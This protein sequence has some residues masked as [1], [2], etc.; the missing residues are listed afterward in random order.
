MSG[1][2]IPPLIAIYSREMISKTIG[3]SLDLRFS[4]VFNGSTLWPWIGS[5]FESLNVGL[6]VVHNVGACVYIYIYITYIYIYTPYVYIYNMYTY[7]YSS[8]LMLERVR[9]PLPFWTDF[10]IS[11]QFQAA[12]PHPVSQVR[13]TPNRWSAC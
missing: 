3:C 2:L 7:S 13:D 10:G 1:I 5:H 4:M 11:G 8:W 6:N 9:Y 12:G